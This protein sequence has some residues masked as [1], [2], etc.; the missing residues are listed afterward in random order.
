VQTQPGPAEGP[1]GPLP[2]GGPEAPPATDPGS[3]KES[4]QS[5]FGFNPGSAQTAE[6]RHRS[7]QSPGKRG[8]RGVGVER[9]GGGGGGGRARLLLPVQTA[10]TVSAIEASVNST[11]LAAA[12]PSDNERLFNFK[13]L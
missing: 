13:I 1:A 12:C 11:L 8:L 4:K 9:A 7:A 10:N 3:A 5:P 6:P 2:C